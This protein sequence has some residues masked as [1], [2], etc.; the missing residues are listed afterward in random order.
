ML[1]DDYLNVD[2][3]KLELDLLFIRVKIDKIVK[4]FIDRDFK[5]WLA[6]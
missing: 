4:T 6:R 3:E 1:E 5:R 2:F